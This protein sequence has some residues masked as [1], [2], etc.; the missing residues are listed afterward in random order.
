[1]DDTNINELNTETKDYKSITILTVGILTVLV[2]ISGAT[3]AFFQA[4]AQV[5]I[6]GQ[7][8]YTTSPLT[9]SVIHVTESSVEDKKLI[10]QN[11]ADI[12]SAVT[13]T[14]N[15]SCVDDDGRAVCQVYSITVANNSETNY[16]LAGTLSFSTN[17]ATTATTG[18]PNL[19][20]A[21]GTSATAGFP[22]SATG[23]FYSSFSTFT[24]NTSA[25]TNTTSLG[26]TFFLNNKNATSGKSQTYYIVV[27][28]SETGSVQT[29]SGTY[30][31]TVTFT[32]YSD[33]GKTLEGVTS[34]IRTNT[35]ST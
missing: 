11:D 3:F 12:Q 2:A 32:A 22:N 6:T 5:T 21:V 7:S 33:D 25:T 19:K 8:A 20:W 30:T 18:M 4:T 23:P 27:W 31:G 35:T 10:P 15:G 26:S 28:I 16:Y 29:D 34:T 24:T 17:P 14:D 9:L 1:M 13:G